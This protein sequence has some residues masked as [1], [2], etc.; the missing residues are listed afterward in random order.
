MY[1]LST[2]DHTRLQRAGVEN[3]PQGI[4]P[5]LSAAVL[6]WISSQEGFTLS[7]LACVEEGDVGPPRQIHPRLSL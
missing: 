2:A 3:Q 5:R 4:L 1:P 6:A 7:Q